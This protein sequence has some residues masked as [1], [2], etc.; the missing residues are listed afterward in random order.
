V[1]T[2]VSPSFDVNGSVN[3]LLRDHPS[4][5]QVIDAHGL[6]T[7]CGGH[8]PLRMAAHRADVTLELLLRD[9][10]QVLQGVR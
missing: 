5:I 3:D 4:V 8:L 2:P 9:I 6:D 1:T 7:C 10:E